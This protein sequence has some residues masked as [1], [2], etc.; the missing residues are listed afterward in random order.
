MP[1]AGKD[2]RLNLKCLSFLLILLIAACGEARNPAQERAHRAEQENGDILIGASAPW[3][4][5]AKALKNGID[6]G[7]QEINAGGG[8]LGRQVRI[9][10]RDDDSSIQKGVVVAQTFADNS[11]IV[12]VIGHF[13]SYVSIPA[14]IIYQY[15]GV[16]ML[17]PTSTASRLTQNGFDLIFRNIPSDE[18]FGH[19]LAEYASRKGFKR[20]IIYYVRDAYGFSLANA[21]SR[22]AMLDGLA[23][24]DRRAYDPYQVQ[25]NFKSDLNEWKNYYEFD[26]IFLAGN[27]PEGAEFIALARKEGISV[28]IIGGDLLNSPDLIRIG[29]KAAEGVV[30]ATSCDTS[31]P[32]PRTAEFVKKYE[33]I[34]HEE[35]NE[36]PAQGYDALKL[37]AYCMQKAK[38]TDPAKVADE[39]RST[40]NWP[41][42]TGLYTFDAN[43]DVVDKEI[44]LRIV[45]GGK[46]RH[47]DISVKR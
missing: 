37:L 35:P 21:F 25:L 30:V 6:M 40:R 5:T 27:I 39:L 41:G 32:R 17:S 4:T 22:Q 2:V 45:R 8:V 3:K 29:G 20:I 12:A 15:F 10:Y 18:A 13:D 24:V 33:N 43:G 31:D 11:N 36:L 28:P 44:Y 34:Y 14:S 9:I 1:A 23:I 42:V 7:L 19:K 46:F 47:L 26:A 16:L 38:S